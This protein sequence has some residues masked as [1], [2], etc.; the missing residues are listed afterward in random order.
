MQCARGAAVVGCGRGS[1]Q[2]PQYV[3]GALHL[4]DPEDRGK[5]Y[6]QQVTNSAHG[7][8]V[9]VFPASPQVDA[10]RDVGDRLGQRAMK[11][12]PK[13]LPSTRRCFC[14]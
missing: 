1:I 8:N 5:Q 4:R 9:R 2:V 7:I 12:F 3:H 6:G 11:T 10:T 14:K 13:R